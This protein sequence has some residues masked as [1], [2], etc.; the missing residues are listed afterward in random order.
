MGTASSLGPRPRDVRRLALQALYV[1]DATG[2]TDAEALLEA[3]DEPTDEGEAA[4]ALEPKLPAIEL[5]L[6]AWSR[7]DEAD[8]MVEQLAPDWP[9]HRQPPIDRAILRL[10]WFE[11]AT[12]RVDIALA[13][14]EAVELAKAFSDERSPAFI[15][16][17]LDRV[18]K[19]VAPEKTTGT[20]P[21]EAPSDASR[22]GDSPAPP[23]TGDAWLDDARGS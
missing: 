1:I 2:Q 23:R 20:K 9:T 21:A 10:G 5:A 15:N 3:L 12:G 18:A 4:V 6:S 14:N 16:G 17:V 13:V 8:A 22:N 11:L 19:R 7:K